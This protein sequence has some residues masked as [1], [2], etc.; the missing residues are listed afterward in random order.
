MHL[1]GGTTQQRSVQ[2]CLRSLLLL[3]GQ[4]ERREWMALVPVSS[5]H[6]SAC[7]PSRALERAHPAHPRY[8]YNKFCFQRTCAPTAALTFAGRGWQH[9]AHVA[10]KL[11]ARTLIHIW[12][13][14]SRWFHLHSKC[15]TVLGKTEHHSP[16]RSP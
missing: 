1:P 3:P 2:P 9:R 16:T 15:I 11:S 4:R 7:P 6:V 8:Y 13:Q 14:K 12:T 10:K 5:L